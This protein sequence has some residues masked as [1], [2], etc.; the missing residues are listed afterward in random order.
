MVLLAQS[1]G[2]EFC[3][4]SQQIKKK[5]NPIAHVWTNT[6]ELGNE[7]GQPRYKWLPCTQKGQMFR[8]MLTLVLHPPLSLTSF[9]KGCRW[10][11]VHKVALVLCSQRHNSRMYFHHG[12]VWSTACHLY[13]SAQTFPTSFTVQLQSLQTVTFN[14]KY[15]SNVPT[16][17]NTNSESSLC[18]NHDFWQHLKVHI[19][20][21]VLR[22][23]RA[24]CNAGI[25]IQKL[26]YLSCN[27]RI[28]LLSFMT[29]ASSGE[30]LMFSCQ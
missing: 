13:L 9:P 2:A 14:I 24:S 23:G 26:I 21:T 5:H 10:H 16:L 29:D 28:I 20:M 8:L 6:A 19:I 15:S 18:C 30:C 27:V 3:I 1:G 11:Q 22:I 25:Y 17:I 7:M 4:C 12:R